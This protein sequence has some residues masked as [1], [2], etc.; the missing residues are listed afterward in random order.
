MQTPSPPSCWQ[1][2]SVCSTGAHGSRGT[3]EL[4]GLCGGRGEAASSEGCDISRGCRYSRGSNLSFITS[5]AQRRL[6]SALAGPSRTPRGISPWHSEQTGCFGTHRDALSS[7][8]QRLGSLQSNTEP[9][10]TSPPERVL[11]FSAV[12]LSLYIFHNLPKCNAGRG[13]SQGNLPGTSIPASSS[14]CRARAGLARLQE[15]LGKAPGWTRNS[16][17]CC[18]AGHTVSPGC[19][20][21]SLAAGWIQAA[22]WFQHTEGFGCTALPG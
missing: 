15:L 19:L 11:W 10:S 3:A 5:Q 2:P 14:R 20:C 18:W 12:L 4:L 16:A 8:V 7:L 9:G 13:A 21:H 1:L 17:W 6:A 22:P